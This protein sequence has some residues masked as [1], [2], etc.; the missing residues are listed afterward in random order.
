MHKIG[1]QVEELVR[2]RLDPHEKGKESEHV[3][4]LITLTSLFFWF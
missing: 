2:S 1:S 4:E 3:H